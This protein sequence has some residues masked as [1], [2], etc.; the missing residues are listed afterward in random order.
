MTIDGII[1]YCDES[2]SALQLG[3]GYIAKK[4]YLEDIPFKNKAQILIE[5]W[6]RHYNTVR[7]HSSLGYR[8]PV[9]AS[10]LVKPT[11]IQWVGLSCVF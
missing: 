1:L 11:Q 4:I 5:L 6:N 10:I 8:T 9:P 3:N 7:P 2:I